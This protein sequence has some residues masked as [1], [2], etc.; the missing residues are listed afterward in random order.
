LICVIRVQPRL[1][2]WSQPRNYYRQPFKYR[3]PTPAAA[4]TKTH[5]TANFIDRFQRSMILSAHL[6]DFPWQLL[7]LSAQNV[8]PYIAIHS[9]IFL[10]V[11]AEL[12]IRE[13][14]VFEYE[15]SF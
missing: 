4:L 9:T 2:L 3:R 7:G 13:Q 6:I 12:S 1:L 8:Q 10:L 14:A 15:P 5:N 11:F